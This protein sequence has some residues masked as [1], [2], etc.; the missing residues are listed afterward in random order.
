MVIPHVLP[1]P[2]KVV[3]KVIRHLIIGESDSPLDH[4]QTS[5]QKN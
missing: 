4:W 2:Q 3:A 1:H 5:G